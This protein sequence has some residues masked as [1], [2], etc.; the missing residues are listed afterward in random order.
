MTSQ[1]QKISVVLCATIVRCLASTAADIVAIVPD[2]YSVFRNG[3]HNSFRTSVARHNVTL[4]IWD[5]G[6]YDPVKN[7]EVFQ[8]AI[9]TPHEEQPQVYLVWPIN[10]ETG[11]LM[12]QLK[13]AHPNSAIIQ[14]QQ[15]PD[16]SAWEYLTAFSGINER[17]KGKL[18]AEMVLQA[19]QK[20]PSRVAVLAYPESY[21]KGLRILES[22]KKRL[23]QEPTIELVA[24]T[25]VAAFGEQE[26]YE[27]VME[28]MTI[29]ADSSTQIDVLHC[30]DDMIL[31]GAFQAL[32]DL[33]MD[34]NITLV[35]SVCNGAREL[36]ETGQ[37][38]GTTIDSPYLIGRYAIGTAVDYMRNGS[39]TERE[40]LY[41]DIPVVGQEWETLLIDVDGEPYTVDDLCTW[42]LTYSRVAGLKV[43]EDAPSHLLC[44][45]VSC[46]FIPTKLFLV[47]YVLAGII[48]FSVLTSAILLYVYRT[49][50][51]IQ[52]AQIP[53]LIMVQ[54]GCLVDT[55]SI[56]FMSRDN[57]DFSQE[58]LDVSCFAW[59]WLICIGHMMTTATLVAKIYRV[60]RVCITNGTG[61][62]KVKVSFQEGAL[63][64]VGFVMID[65]ILLS[66]WY[67]IA[68]LK[69]KMEASSRDA[70]GSISEVKGQCQPAGNTDV[71][72][73][74]PVLLLIWHGMVLV[75]AN[76]LVYETRNL[77]KLSDSKHVAIAVFNS[78]Q[79]LI[80]TISLIFGGNSEDASYMI[81]VFFVFL[82]N[83]C[84][85]FLVV[86]RKIYACL[87]GRGGE[88]PNIHDI[89]A[90]QNRSRDFR[91]AL[92]LEGVGPGD[93]HDSHEE[94]KPPSQE[95]EARESKDE[96]EKAK[97]LSTA[98][99]E[100]GNTGKTTE[101]FPVSR[102][103]ET[104]SQ[105]RI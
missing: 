40:R 45:V 67:A 63:F 58:Q 68:P 102:Q 56:P 50:A 88:L 16:P 74:F 15:Y 90:K 37:Q 29:M 99:D 77:H 18:A 59:P 48:Y 32:K 21:K 47:G 28:M 20:A 33:G 46:S 27:S 76:V 104:H 26:A 71:F 72:W 80:L 11:T 66:I 64:I 96:V 86:L 30:M 91:S 10:E 94:G 12:R 87:I 70:A 34:Q 65:V 69:W 81:R 24:E 2:R 62:R 49:K 54:V 100:S 61:F 44:T 51:V 53:F 38:W 98:F 23:E 14:I 73:V 36:L 41:E 75:Y 105:E 3:L 9:A 1:L 31:T 79:L 55:T 101:S 7:E 42:S 85:L 17:A 60:K 57:R 82:N 95:L 93:L 39:P 25:S 78:L 84:V 8:Q 35:G 6:N 92:R 52:I 5:V 13:E 43:V 22:F 19:T 83:L 97:E 103:P 89:Q 4:E